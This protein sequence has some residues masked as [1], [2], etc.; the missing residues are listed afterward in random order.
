MKDIAYYDGQIGPIDAVKAPI[1]DRGLYFGDGVYEAAMV[2][3]QRIFALDDHLDRFFSSL[4]L[5]RIEPPMA[6]DALAA[7]LCDLVARLDTT[8][9]HILYWQSTRGAAHRQHAFPAHAKTTLMAFAEPCPLD[10]RDRPYKLLTVADTRFLHCNIKTLNLIPNCMAMQQAVEAGCDEVVFHRDGRVTEGAHSSLAL[11]RDGVFCTP[12][13]DEL[14]LPS[15]T[16]KHL[17]ALC[18]QLGVPTRVAPFT[19]D[20]LR[21]ADEILLLATGTHCIAACSLDGQPIGGKDPA[22]LDR[23]QTAYQAMFDQLTTR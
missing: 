5:L 2:R 10:R 14:V 22:L 6:R 12:P 21:T 7:V 11:L 18:E 8:A 15:I 4:S 3:D 20:E 16:R 23:L 13:A 17:L 1:T 19:V 9:P